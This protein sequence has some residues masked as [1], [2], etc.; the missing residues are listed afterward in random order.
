MSERGMSAPADR[1][2]LVEETDTQSEIWKY[3]AIVTDSKVKPLDTT[4]PVCKRCF[5][6]VMTN[7]ANTSS[8]VKHQADRHANLFKE[9]KELQVSDR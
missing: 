6:S 7:G 8:S 9:F 5:K 1:P 4:K 3:F 2:M